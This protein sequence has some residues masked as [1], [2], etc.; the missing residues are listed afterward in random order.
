[1]PRKHIGAAAGKFAGVASQYQKDKSHSV[2]HL[3]N[4]VDETAF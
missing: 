1:M 2:L 3:A 4:L